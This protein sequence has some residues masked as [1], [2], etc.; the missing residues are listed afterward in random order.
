MTVEDA[1]GFPFQAVLPSGPRWTRWCGLLA[2]YIKVGQQVTTPSG[3][4]AQRVKLSKE[5]QSTGNTALHPG[6]RRPVCTLRDVRN[7]WKCASWW[8][9]ATWSS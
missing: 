2:G 8:I 5:R 3:G 4:E 9:R 6:C 1:Q 7:R